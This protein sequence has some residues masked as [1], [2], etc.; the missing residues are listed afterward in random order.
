MSDSCLLRHWM[1]G[2]IV[3]PDNSFS[4]VIS[5]I[6]FSNSN[7]KIHGSQYQGL[8]SIGTAFISNWSDSASHILS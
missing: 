1:G 3:T 7:S 4:E 6:S 2:G 5:D 8:H